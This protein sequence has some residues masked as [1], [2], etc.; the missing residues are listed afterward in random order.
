MLMAFVP[1][2]AW[3]LGMV[4]GGAAKFA[5]A[6]LPWFSPAAYGFVVV[7][8]L[9]VAGVTGVVR[10]RKDVQILLPMFVAGLVVQGAAIFASLRH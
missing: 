2:G 8:G 1:F 3:M 5:I 9:L 10:R 6:L 7:A 4:G